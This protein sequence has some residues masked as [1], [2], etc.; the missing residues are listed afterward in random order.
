MPSRLQFF[1]PPG[2]GR[3][4][5]QMVSP[6]IDD[7]NKPF[8][9]FSKPTDE[10]G[11]MGSEGATEITPEGYLRTGF[12]ELMFFSGPDLVPTSVRIRTLEEGHLPIDH[13]EFERDGII[14][15]FTMF[16]AGLNADQSGPL[17]NFIR[18]TMRN[19]TSQPTRAICFNRYSLRRAEH[20]RRTDG[21][22][23]VLPARRGAFSREI[24]GRLARSSAPTGKTLLMADISSAM[25][26]CSTASL[27]AI[28]RAAL[29]S[30]TGSAR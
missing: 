2:A 4:T 13:Y 17:V 28:R 15:R 21:R 9:Y 12:G 7:P 25:V 24:T 23:P 14:Y 5:A 26:V 20:H 22:Q 3:L 27:Q 8:T 10:I 11:V 29:C 19:A 18:V 30:E 16:E 6:S 1:P